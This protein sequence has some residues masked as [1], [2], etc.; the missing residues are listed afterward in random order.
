V[1]DPETAGVGTFNDQVV[2]EVEGLVNCPVTD[3]VDGGDATQAEG[4]PGHGGGV[5]RVEA[6]GA[7]GGSILERLPHR[8]GVPP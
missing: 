2:E 8:R 4:G 7:G 3:G 5:A 6:E 1:L